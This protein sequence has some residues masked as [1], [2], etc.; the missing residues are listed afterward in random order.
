MKLNMT[1][2]ENDQSFG[3]QF[4]EVQNISDGGFERGYAE[5]S[6]AGHKIGYAEGHTVGYYEGLDARTYETWTITYAD[7]STEEKEVALL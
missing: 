4:G 5:G 6:V 3:L 7:G 2:K 1:F